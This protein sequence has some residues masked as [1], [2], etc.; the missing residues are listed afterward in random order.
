MKS[1]YLLEFRAG[2]ELVHVVV[3][4]ESKTQ[5]RPG[6]PL[7]LD[8][9]GPKDVFVTHRCRIIERLLAGSGVETVL[10]N[11]ITV[12]NLLPEQRSGLQEQKGHRRARTCARDSTVEGWQT[13][14]A[15]RRHHRHPRAE[16]RHLRVSPDRLE[17]TAKLECMFAAD[18]GQVFCR[19]EVLFIV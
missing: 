7:V 14:E 4:T 10:E 11:W 2:G 18:V 17:L 13:K 15:L 6:F 19:L 12:G 3:N 9:S 16:Q 1:T 5:I 8:V